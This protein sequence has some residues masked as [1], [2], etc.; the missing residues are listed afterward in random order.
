MGFFFKMMIISFLTY[1]ITRSWFAVVCVG[2]ITAVMSSPDEMMD[3][4]MK[5]ADKVRKARMARVGAD[6]ITE[7][8]VFEFLD[9]I[10]KR[11]R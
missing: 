11:T 9:K 7:V 8:Y 6:N 5:E 2:F 3:D 4:K 10:F 1:F